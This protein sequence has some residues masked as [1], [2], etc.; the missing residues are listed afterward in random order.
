MLEGVVL[1][2]F[3]LTA[4]AVASFAH[5]GVL[6][7]FDLV[8]GRSEMLLNRAQMTALN[9]RFPPMLFQLMRTVN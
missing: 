6:L 3:V 4:G 5:R 9:V 7:G 8:S 1:L 2:W